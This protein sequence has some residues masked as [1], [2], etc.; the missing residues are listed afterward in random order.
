MTREVP[1]LA[2]V[3]D[4]EF[5]QWGVSSGGCA[6][7]E[8]DGWITLA[9]DTDAILPWASVTKVV[10]ALAVLDVVHDGTLSLDDPVGPKG[11]T[12]RH[13]LGHASGLAF[14]E[15]RVIA[16]PGMRRIYSNVGIDLA[17]A[18]AVSAAGAVDAQSL[19]ADRILAPLG[20]NHTDLRGPAAHGAWGPVADLALL[21]REL[22]SPCALR[23][24]VIRDAVTP[25]FPNLAGVLPGFGRQEPNDWGLGVEIRGFKSPHWMPDAVSAEAFGHFGQTGSYLWVDSVLGVASVTLTGT[26]FGRWASDA[27]PRSG[28]RWLE[29][30]ASA[31]RSS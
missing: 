1:T 8:A 22:L 19:I 24:V 29:A 27:W 23:P 20:M 25:S 7:V 28:A 26:A 13:L 30:R 18:A 6:L 5:S 17:V 11:A 9:G 3:L 15:L 21:A 10:A 4:E 31:R 16:A 2:A 12:V 14:D